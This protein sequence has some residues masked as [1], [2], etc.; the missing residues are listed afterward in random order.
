MADA[1]SEAIYLAKLSEQAERYDGTAYY[2]CFKSIFIFISILFNFD[3]MCE[4]FILTYI[5]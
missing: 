5:G 4:F 1:R 2:G 3:L